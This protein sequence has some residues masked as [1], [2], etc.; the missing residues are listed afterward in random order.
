M[1]FS[2][3]TLSSVQRPAHHVEALLEPAHALALRHAERVE[4]GLAIAEP[5]AEDEIAAPDRVERGDALGDL[6]R[7]VQ[8]GQQHPG[9]AGHLA[10][11]GR[12]P[13]QKRDQLQLA[14]ALA[15]IMLAAGDGVPAAVAREAGHRV[16]AFELGKDVAAGRVLAGQE[17]A[18]FHIASKISCHQKLR[19]E[20]PGLPR[21][22]RS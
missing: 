10:G 16:L 11:L 5:D 1:S 13:R 6:D 21:I 7:V 20:P 14:H 15:Q 22:R 2:K 4:L 3:L 18:D 17:D 19:R 8:A 12:E 9:D